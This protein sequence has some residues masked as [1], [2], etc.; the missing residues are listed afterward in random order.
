M[1]RWIVAGVV[2][3]L[4]MGAGGFFA[5]KSYRQN[6]PAPVWVPMPVNPE[7]PMARRDEI[8]GDLKAKLSDRKLLIQVSRDVGLVSKWGLVSDEAGAVEIGRRLFVRAG[9]A[10]TPMGK[11]PAVHIGVNGKR[12]EREVSGQIAMRL[13]EDV[14][15]ILGIKPPEKR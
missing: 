9:D 7:L 3:M 2:A 1:Q 12:K 6:K 4:L 14:W 13:M 10:D 8:I 11:V 15:K 5:L